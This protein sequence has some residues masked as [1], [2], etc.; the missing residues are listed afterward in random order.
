[1]CDA[2]TGAELFALKGHTRAV[3]DL[4]FSPDGARI[5]TG[6]GD[7]TAR[8]WDAKTGAELFALKG[9]TDFVTCVAFSPDRARIL[10]GSYDKTARMWD[11]KSRAEL[12]ALK[13]HT[14]AVTS[15]AFSPD[16]AHILTGSYDNTARVWDAK[17][18]AELFALKGHTGPVTG[19]AFSPDGARILT[20]SGDN[21]ARMWDAKTGAELFA[22]KGHS[23][24]VYSVAFS[25]DG[26]RILTGSWDKSAWLWDAKRRAKLFALEGHTGAVTSVAFSPDGAHILT[27]SYDKTARLWDAKTGAE[28]FALKGHTGPV[29]SVVFS[30]DGARILTGSNDNT[31]R[32]WDHSLGQVSIAHGSDAVLRC[33]TSEQRKAFELSSEPLEWCYRLEK[34]PY[35]HITLINQSLDFIRSSDDNEAE[36]LIAVLKRYHPVLAQETDREWADAYFARGAEALKHNNEPAAAIA[37]TKAQALDPS[38]KERI[39]KAKIK[40]G[41]WLLNA[42]AW[43]SLLASKAA[44]GVD[45]AEGA[46]KLSPDIPDILNTRA[47]IYLALER[48]DEA[49]T[50]LD[51]AI[52]EGIQLPSTYY[53]RGAIYEKR[54]QTELA[55]ADYRKTLELPAPADGDDARWEADAK[56]KAE[57]HLAALEPPAA[58]SFAP[59]AN[60]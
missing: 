25:P 57:A 17:T 44:A 13:G 40:A 7:N 19:V 54:S 24:P 48:F 22:L 53:S 12:F 26:A 1:V 11:T 49:L 23:G 46:V 45:D 28:L 41:A 33:L 2:K 8:V 38:A 60:R 10:T 47:Q 59:P 16:G 15:V 34:W 29:T 35:D 4:H 27:G 58:A 32:L 3:L 43:K 51:K 18:G 6:S 30:R 50:D 20:G 31:A 21:T 55:I 14:G 52:A 56:A 5:L 9:H 42:K 36:A 37:F 39:E